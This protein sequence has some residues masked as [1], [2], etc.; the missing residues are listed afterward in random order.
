MRKSIFILFIIA[1]GCNSDNLE[2]KMEQ[3][4]AEILNVETAFNNMAQSD[5][6]SKAFQYYAAENGVIKRGKDVIKGKSNIGEWYKKDV[7]PNE[8]LFWK[9][10]YVDVSESGDMAY[11]YG[12]YTFSYQ[13]SLGNVQSSKGIFHTVWKRQKDGTWRFVYD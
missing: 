6:L 9:P 7:K 10:T 1:I 3:W 5:G 13:D 2:S 11:T 8:T 4:K 12:D